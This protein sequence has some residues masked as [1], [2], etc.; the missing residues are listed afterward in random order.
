L[1]DEP[2]PVERAPLAPQPVLKPGALLRQ[3]DSQTQAPRTVRPT[4]AASLEP[5]V[6][7]P[8]PPERD[9]TLE[10][11]VSWPATA[12]PPPELDQRQQ[13]PHRLER[14]GSAARAPGS[15]P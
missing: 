9:A 1:A 14:S 10:E 8:D 2:E 11:T 13:R 6:E 4:V 7:P 15:S 12:M 3:N 5:A